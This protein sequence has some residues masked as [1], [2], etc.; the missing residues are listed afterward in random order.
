MFFAGGERRASAWQAQR[1][2][3]GAPRRRDD[4]HSRQKRAS[5]FMRELVAWCRACFRFLLLCGSA[6][7]ARAAVGK[8]V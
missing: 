5:L 4:R 3:K 1:R 2:W 7:A 8:A 6:R